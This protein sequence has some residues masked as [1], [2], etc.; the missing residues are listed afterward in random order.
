[1][2]LVRLNNRHIIVWNWIDIQ[3]S[4]LWSPVLTSTTFCRNHS[5]AYIW[6]N[7]II[8][9][10]FW[11]PWLRF[12]FHIATMLLFDIYLFFRPSIYKFCNYRFWNFTTSI[13]CLFACPFPFNLR[14]KPYICVRECGVEWVFNQIT[15][16]IEINYK[17]T[18]K[19]ITKKN[20]K[21]YKK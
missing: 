2:I 11:K 14:M 18:Y 10:N 19:N 15:K 20:K 7:S 3:M 5:R 8:F 17:S 16:I 6:V 13:L 4:N 21:I 12:W 9:W 1:M